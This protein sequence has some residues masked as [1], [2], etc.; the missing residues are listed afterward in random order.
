MDRVVLRAFTPLRQASRSWF[1]HFAQLKMIMCKSGFSC[2]KLFKIVLFIKVSYHYIWYQRTDILL[3]IS[4]YYY[5]T[6]NILVSFSI[7]LSLP[8]LLLPPLSF[9]PSLHDFFRNCGNI[10]RQLIYK[11]KNDHLRNTF[12]CWD[13]EM[14][15][16]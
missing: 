10:E 5:L 11:K 7:C 9:L 12:W 13:L 2:S 8:L 15:A 3:T 1:F 4:F 14:R 16:M 6:S